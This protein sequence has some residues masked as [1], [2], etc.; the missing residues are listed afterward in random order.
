MSTSTGA[1]GRSKAGREVQAEQKRS[2]LMALA[3]KGRSFL[4]SLGVE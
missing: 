3:V 1:A 2:Q 4:I